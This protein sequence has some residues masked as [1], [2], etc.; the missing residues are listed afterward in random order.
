MSKTTTPRRLRSVAA[1]VPA[2]IGGLMDARFV[3]VPAAAT[4]IRAT[5]ERIRAQQP[6]VKG[7]S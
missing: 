3:Y 1:P 2:P 6:L 7:K 4:D 5:F